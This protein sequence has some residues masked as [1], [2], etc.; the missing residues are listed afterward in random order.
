MTPVPVKKP[1]AKQA[2][3]PVVPATPVKVKYTVAPA[4]KISLDRPKNLNPIS[5]IKYFWNL[6]VFVGIIPVFKT[7][8]VLNVLAW[9]MPYILPYIKAFL[10]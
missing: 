2:P 7:I 6:D 10:K 5:W 4:V 1:V 8:I 9:A 3:K